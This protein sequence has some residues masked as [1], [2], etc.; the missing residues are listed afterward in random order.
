MRCFVAVPIPATLRA[1]LGDVQASLRDRLQGARW[2]RPE[3][4]HLTLRFLGEIDET[5][6]ARLGT[7]LGD[8]V[9]RCG[10]P[11][12]LRLGGVGAFPPRGR[13]RVLWIGLGNPEDDPEALE[14]LGVLQSCIERTV[15]A[16][17]VS[18]ETRPFHPHLTLARF[19]QR[20]PRGEVGGSQGGGIVAAQN[21]PVDSVRLYRSTLS[22][23]G[24]TYDVLEEYPL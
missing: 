18:A 11:F 9:K 24:A 16:A 6:R 20:A 15:R 13:P 4:I 19:D 8:P 14:R 10:P 5:M 2:V 1:A 17:G 12:A 7:S 3:G 22:G 21:L 23:S